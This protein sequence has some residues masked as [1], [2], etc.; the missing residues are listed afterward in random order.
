MTAWHLRARSRRTGAL[1]GAIAV[2]VAGCTTTGGGSGPRADRAGAAGHSV[3]ASPPGRVF[4]HRIA[5]IPGPGA[6]KHGSG[7]GIAGAS[8][9]A[10]CAPPL[11]GPAVNGAGAASRLRVAV[12]ACLCCRWCACAWAC[13]GCSPGRWPP[14]WWPPRSH[15][16]W[17][18]CPRW[19]GPPDWDSSPIRSACGPGCASPACPVGPARSAAGSV[20]ARSPGGAV[21][22]A[23]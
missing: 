14:R 7:P 22:G 9:L 13:C 11:G 19:L 6:V 10:P 17:Q 2:L 3:A 18:C 5:G 8:S 4:A 21:A 15:L 12:P 1:L 20:Q 16:A 23:G